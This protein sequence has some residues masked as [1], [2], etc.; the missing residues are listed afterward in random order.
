MPGPFMQKCEEISLIERFAEVPALE[1]PLLY[2]RIEM[3]PDSP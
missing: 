1:L 2:G 3:S